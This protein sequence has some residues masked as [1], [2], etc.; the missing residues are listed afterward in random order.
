MIFDTEHFEKYGTIIFRPENEKEREFLKT[1]FDTRHP[2][3][4]GLNADGSISLI[5]QESKTK[6]MLDKGIVQS[7]T[8]S[9]NK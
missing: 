1:L 4:F 7:S 8:G 6:W 2:F 3:T 9:A 5:T